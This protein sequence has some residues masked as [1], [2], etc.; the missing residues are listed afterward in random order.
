[1]G[2]ARSDETALTCG[3]FVRNPFG[4]A[5]AGDVERLGLQVAV[6]PPDLETGQ[7]A[8]VVYLLAEVQAG[9]RIHEIG[10]RAYVLHAG[11]DELTL[12]L[13]GSQ[14]EVVHCTP[15]HVVARR[16][17]FALRRDHTA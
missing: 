1:V 3:R 8:Q 14:P 12:E 6:P 5:T 7:P 2:P 13:G 15:A 16:S 9:G 17:G 4:G 10:S 11:A